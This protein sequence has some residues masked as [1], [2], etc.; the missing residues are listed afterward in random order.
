MKIQAGLPRRWIFFVSGPGWQPLDTQMTGTDINRQP[1]KETRPDEAT[2]SMEVSA[3]RVPVTDDTGRVLGFA[4]GIIDLAEP[5]PQVTITPLWPGF[6][7]IQMPWRQIRIGHVRGNVL[8]ADRIYTNGKVIEP[9]DAEYLEGD[10]RACGS[11]LAVCPNQEPGR[12]WFVI[13]HEDRC[14]AFAALLAGE[15]IE[16]EQ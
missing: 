7:R 3:M 5:E 1:Q 2:T 10:C 8:R 15:L 6:S 13:E 14:P 4:A 11:S 9:T 12:T 16:D